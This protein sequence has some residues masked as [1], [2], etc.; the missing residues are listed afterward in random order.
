MCMCVSFV[1]S[2]KLSPTIV[3]NRLYTLAF[4]SH[5]RLYLYHCCQGAQTVVLF[6]PLEACGPVVPTYSASQ[7]GMMC[8]GNSEMMMLVCK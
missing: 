8:R 2:G 5:S 7:T 1:S 3:N 4:G 6:L